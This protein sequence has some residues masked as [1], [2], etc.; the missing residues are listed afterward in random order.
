METQKLNRT[1]FQYIL[2]AVGIPGPNELARLIGSPVMAAQ[3]WWHK[4]TVPKA[5]TAA[6][7]V[8]EINKRKCTI[9]DEG[10]TE[11][12]RPYALR[13]IYPADLWPQDFDLRDGPIQTFRSWKYILGWDS[14][15]LAAIVELSPSYVAKTASG[16]QFSKG[17]K[18]L[19]L[20]AIRDAVG[21]PEVEILW[22]VNKEG[23]IPEFQ[24]QEDED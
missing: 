9:L 24:E 5:K 8:E 4:G 11:E 22:G 20:L 1:Y 16:S 17:A 10:M 7:I 18:A 3:N 6:A 12:L 19:I 14:E 21:N 23:G 13:K 15:Q 2:K